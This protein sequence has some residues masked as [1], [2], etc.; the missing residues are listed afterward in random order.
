MYE[1]E[2]DHAFIVLNM[3]NGTLC[4]FGSPVLLKE[5]TNFFCGYG[6]TTTCNTELIQ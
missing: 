6:M 5:H 2:F 4:L 3:Y 1:V